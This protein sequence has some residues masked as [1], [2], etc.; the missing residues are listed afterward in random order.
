MKIDIM[1]RVEVEVDNARIIRHVETPTSEGGEE[2]EYDVK[3]LKVN[4][5]SIRCNGGWIY[6]D[7]IG[8]EIIDALNKEVRENVLQD[9]RDRVIDAA[10]NKIKE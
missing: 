5:A 2:L 1:V 4:G 9:E 6:A 3:A 10:I 7:E 8:E